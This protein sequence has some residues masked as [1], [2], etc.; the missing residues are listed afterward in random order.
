VK[1]ALFGLAKSQDQAISIVN[2]LNGAGF[3]DGD[4]SVL[5]PDN[6]ETRHFAHLQ[7]TRAPEGLTSGACLGLVIGAVLGWLLGVGVLTIPGIG[8]FLAAGPIMAALA[9]AALCATVGGLVGALIGMEMP[10]FEAVQYQAKMDGGNILISVLTRDANERHRVEEIFKNAG[11]VTAAEAV[12]DHAYRRP[13]GAV[14]AAMSPGSANQPANAS[15][16][17]MSRSAL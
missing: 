8:P 4:I 17:P 1:K 14:G 5:F 15:R 16:V 7:R 13:V 10:Q 12:V 6:T 2:Q 9:G 11:S 3:L